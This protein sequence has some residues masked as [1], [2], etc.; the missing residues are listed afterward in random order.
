MKKILLIATLLLTVLTIGAQRNREKKF[1]PQKFQADLEQFIVKEACLTPSESAA[2]FPQYNEMKRKQRVVFDKQRRLDRS[3][4]Q[5]E[6]DCR[7]AIKERDKLDLELKKIQ[8]TY[9]NKFL[10][11]LSARKVF[12]VLKAE[13]R[14]HRRVLR[15][16]EK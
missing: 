16:S 9:H 7:N 2:F 12:N 13:D 15:K 6:A 8:Q 4:P 10:N 11:I 1:S 3:N 5:S 14:F